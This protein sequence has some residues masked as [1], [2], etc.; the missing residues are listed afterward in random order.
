MSKN[1]KTAK[2]IKTLK[3]PKTTRGT[4]KA[5][6]EVNSRANSRKTSQSKP[7]KS[8]KPSR[9][10]QKI[11]QA[12]LFHPHQKN[13]HLFCK[14]VETFLEEPL[15]ILAKENA[16][17]WI[18]MDCC[19]N[20]EL[21]FSFWQIP[22]Q[23]QKAFLGAIVISDPD[24]ASI[25]Q[26]QNSKTYT[27]FSQKIPEF[28]LQELSESR[29]GIPPELLPYL[30]SSVFTRKWLEAGNN[31]HDVI[32]G[33]W[34]Q[35]HGP[36][37]KDR[38]PIHW[39]FRAI[40]SYSGNAGNFGSG[41]EEL[42][43]SILPMRALS[44]AFLLV[45]NVETILA[46]PELSIQSGAG[47]LEEP[48]NRKNLKF[49]PAVSLFMGCSEKSLAAPDRAPDENGF[50]SIPSAVPKHLPQPALRIPAA[51]LEIGSFPPHSKSTGLSEPNS[52]NPHFPVLAR[53]AATMTGWKRLD[54]LLNRETGLSKFL[55]ISSR[56]AKL[57]SMLPIKTTDVQRI[58]ILESITP[59]YRLSTHSVEEILQ[60]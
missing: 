32:P 36:K 4:P 7:S 57:Y 56:S 13:N 21:K 16:H 10:I 38:N 52:Q 27:K 51:R 55:K 44:K 46:S 18:Q 28:F 54:S 23:G 43:K 11:S 39:S 30:G 6:S 37:M 3:I 47:W 33:I 12:Q 14:S 45:R 42:Q 60:D 35:R 49:L 19:S 34:I 53:A 26:N 5:S 20:Q 22:K 59:Q 41:S 25:L 31:L 50:H 8:S 1:L 24:T 40:F 48:K 2:T 15:R 58:L 9:K 17:S 29:I